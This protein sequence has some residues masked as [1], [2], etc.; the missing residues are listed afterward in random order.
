M[1]ILKACF[2]G[3]GDLSTE[4]TPIQNKKKARYSCNSE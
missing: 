3:N 2:H 1:M 4:I